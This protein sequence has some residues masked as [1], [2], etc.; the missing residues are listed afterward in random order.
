MSGYVD[1]IEK[2]SQYNDNF[3]E[4]LFTSGKMQ[5]VVMKLNAG[6]DIG[7]EVHDKVDQFIRVE[8]GEGMAVLDGEET[9]IYD[10][11]AVV[12]PAGTKHNIIN[13]GVDAMK[14]YTIYTPPQHRERTVHATKADAIADE[15]DHY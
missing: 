12:I 15:G 6:E 1:N 14:L 11:F 7:E 3:R 2:K 8:S 10:G 4:V 5:L 13:Q 9:K